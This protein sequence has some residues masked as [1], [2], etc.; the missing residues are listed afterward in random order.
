MQSIKD[1]HLYQNIVL[2]RI[3]TKKAALL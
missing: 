2:Q 3:I 1:F